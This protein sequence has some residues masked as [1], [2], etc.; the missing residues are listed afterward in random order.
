MTENMGRQNS[1]ESLKKEELSESE[2]RAKIENQSK[3]VDILKKI[4]IMG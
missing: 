2:L 1:G 3:K 4:K